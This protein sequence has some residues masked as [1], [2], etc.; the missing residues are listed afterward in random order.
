MPLVVDR[1]PVT[2]DARAIDLLVDAKFRVIPIDVRHLAVAEVVEAT[3][4]PG[5]YFP[6]AEKIFPFVV[7]IVKRCLNTRLK[8]NVTRSNNQPATLFRN[9]ITTFGEDLIVIQT[10]LRS[11]VRKSR[12]SPVFFFKLTKR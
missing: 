2:D 8:P 11:I 12:P 1:V 4:R 10:C 5:E 3:H 6:R 7:T 9:R